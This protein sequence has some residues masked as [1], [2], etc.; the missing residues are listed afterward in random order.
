VACVNEILSQIEDSEDEILEHLVFEESE[1][2]MTFNDFEW[3]SSNDF[4]LNLVF[5]HQSLWLH[6]KFLDYFNHM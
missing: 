5:H 4:Q 2:L 3:H 1:D 6:N